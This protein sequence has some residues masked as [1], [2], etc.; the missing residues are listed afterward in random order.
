MLSFGTDLGVAQKEDCPEVS[1]ASPSWSLFTLVLLNRPFK[2]RTECS[3]VF[4]TEN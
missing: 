4:N 3:R 1:I 2:T